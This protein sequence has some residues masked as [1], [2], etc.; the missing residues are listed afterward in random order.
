MSMV[1][2]PVQKDLEDTAEALLWVLPCQGSGGWM[3]D[4]GRRDSIE[5]RERVVEPECGASL[6]PIQ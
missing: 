1:S 6:F 4:L 2:G 3:G 5:E